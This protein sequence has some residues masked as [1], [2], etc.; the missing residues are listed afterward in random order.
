[1]DN[2]IQQLQQFAKLMSS[3]SPEE[4]K[5]APLVFEAAELIANDRVDHSLAIEMD[6]FSAWLLARSRT[7]ESHLLAEAAT[8]L[9]GSQ[10]VPQV[11]ST[12]PAMLDN[13]K[14]ESTASHRGR[15]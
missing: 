8:L 5:Y 9:K 10:I 14:H 1:M 7:K 12:M 4:R 6:I 11:D 3:Q 2:R 15:A 13:K